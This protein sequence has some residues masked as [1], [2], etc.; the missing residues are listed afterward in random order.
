MAHQQSNDTSLDY[1]T[2]QLTDTFVDDGII[3]QRS[4]SKTFFSDP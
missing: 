4:I 3:Y 1:A 2:S